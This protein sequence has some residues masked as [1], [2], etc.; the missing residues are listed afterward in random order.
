M[1]CD[2]LTKSGNDNFYKRLRDTMQTGVFSLQ[3]S[4]DSIIRKMRAQK[5]RSDRAELAGTTR[6]T[7]KGEHDLDTQEV[8]PEYAEMLNDPRL[9]F[10]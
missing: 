4:N 6:V 10:D 9:Q 5:A 2:P 8:T 7:L 1:I 3:A